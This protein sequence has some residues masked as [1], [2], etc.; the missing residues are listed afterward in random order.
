MHFDQGFR[1]LGTLFLRSLDMPAPKKKNHLDGVN[2]EA[3]TTSLPATLVTPM[4]RVLNGALEKAGKS[5]LDFPVS[6]LKPE[7]QPVPAST[8]E[9]G[10][11]TDQAPLPPESQAADAEASE[12]LPRRAH[13]P[14]RRTLYIQE[15]GSVLAREDERLI[16]KKAQETLLE[17]PAAKI[18]Q[19][20]IFGNCTITTPAM[21]Y[22]LKEDIPIVLFS[23]RGNYYGII[24][25]PLG[26][27]VSL[28]QRQ[29]TRA[30]DPEF[31]LTTAKTLI[32]AKLHNCR[33]LLQRHQRRKKIAAIAA[34]I[35]RL[36]EISV[37]LARAATV[38]EVNGYE[39][40]GAAQ[41]FAAV[42]QLVDPPFRFSQRTRQ[43]PTDPVNSL[44]SLGYT[45]LFYNLYALITARGL[46]PYVGHLHLMRDRHP[47][48][49]SDLIEEFRAPIVDSLVLYLVNSKL[50]ALT[51]FSRLP[52]GPCLLTD[53]ARKTF[54]RFFEQ[55][56]LTQVT[57]PHTGIVVD[58]RRCLDLQVCQ[59]ADWIRG[60]VAAYQPMRI[61]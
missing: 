4:A 3:V 61:R 47:A 53:S 30:A 5:V 57:H 40:A 19:I 31:C 54:F 38:E 21:T 44:L 36:G 49:A 7:A 22:C 29:F 35:E 46:H 39:G 13:V 11:E 17:V 55:K 42:G 15:Q 51:D 56:M 12:A 14:F 28:H 9:A 34:A 23:S 16:V 59:M 52:N 48:L 37:R 60:N 43:P 10:T 27:N 1:Y 45:L 24:D 2:K 33:V 18:D 58:Y 32:E 6:E 50:F 20:F 26:D 25:S 8:N 41:Y